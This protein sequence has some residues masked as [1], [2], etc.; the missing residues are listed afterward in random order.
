MKS[1]FAS[2][3]IWG[4]LCAFLGGLT[5]TVPAASAQGRDRRVVTVRRAVSS[6]RHRHRVVRNVRVRRNGHWVT[7]RRVTYR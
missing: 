6:G 5:F 2:V 7:V 1:R 3:C 4:M